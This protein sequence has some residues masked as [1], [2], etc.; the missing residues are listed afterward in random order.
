LSWKVRS[1]HSIANQLAYQIE[2]SSSPHFSAVLADSGWVPSSEQIGQPSPAIPPT[3]RESQFFRVRIETEHGVTDWSS[4]LHYEAGLLSPSDWTAVP[5]GD[6]SPKESASPILRREIELRARPVKARLYSTSMGLN[7]ISING[8]PVSSGLLNPGWT[9]YQKRLLVETFDVTNL[10]S[11]GKNTLGAVLSDGWWRGK[12]GFMNGSE[13][14]GTEIGLLAQL[15]VSYEDGT[16]ETFCTDSNWRTSSAEILFSS[17]YDGSTI[18]FNRQQTGW[19]LND[20]DDSHWSEVDIKQLDLSHL[21][22]RISDPVQVIAELPMALEQKPDRVLLRGTQNISGWVRLV[23]SG[24]KGQQVTVRHAEVLE[25][26][27]KLHTAALRSAKATDVYILDK[28]GVTIL[29]P[30]FTF[31]GFQYADVVTEA[32]VVS[33]TAVAISSA[34]SKRALLQTSHSGLNRLHENVVWSQLDNFLSIPTD[35]PQRDERMGWT[36]DAQAFAPTANT[37]F[38]MESFWRSWL[39]DLEL[40]QFENGDVSAV[41]PDIMKLYPAEEGWIF[42]GRAGWADAATIIPMATYE[43]YGDKSI[44]RQQLNSMRRWTDALVARMAGGELLPTEFQ[45]GDWCDPDAPVNRP[46]ESKVS[47]DFVANSFFANTATLM[48]RTERLVGDLELAEHYEELAK[49]LRKA[50]WSRFGSTAVLTTAGCSIALAFDIAPESERQ[51]V[52]DSLAAIVDRDQG[53]ISTGFL[54]T[55]LILHAL[56]KNGH[57][58]SAFQMLLRREFRSWLYTV[59]KGATTMWERW[60]AIREDGSINTGSMDDDPNSDGGGSMMS[61]N[62]YA[63]GSVMDWVYQNIGGLALVRDFPGYR[64]VLV[65]PKLHRE[66]EF[67][68]TSIV[69]PYG[70]ISFDWRLTSLGSWTAELKIPFGVTAV[71]DLPAKKGSEVLLNGQSLGTANELT[72]GSYQLVISEPSI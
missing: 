5:I 46:W 53:M 66:V 51:F 8:L 4:A 69:S 42:E 1:E 2:V 70:D 32:E 13:H 62:H 31:H 11:S 37:L 63:Y 15:E 34:T 23:V 22:E 10:L 27:D 67:A 25:P 57:L 45:F 21:S 48:A 54:A 64:K 12:F 58:G 9:S 29:E 39:I 28:E 16:F 43:A 47:P 40:D 20:F 6:E 44:L 71:L 36:G 68:K 50:I 59:D 65:S 33:A 3:S 55:P 7:N 60:D 52:A 17:I 56:S 61:F 14:Y 38:D 72:A 19:Q 35:C 18:D 49:T 30:Q 26:D 41:V 24:K